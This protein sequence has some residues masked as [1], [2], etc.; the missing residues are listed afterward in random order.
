[1][2]THSSSYSVKPLPGV[3]LGNG[4]DS[5]VT[6]VDLE[7]CSLHVPLGLNDWELS[8]SKGAFLLPCL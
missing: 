2:P 7:D 3:F 4:S 6:T 5:E 8:N 1:M